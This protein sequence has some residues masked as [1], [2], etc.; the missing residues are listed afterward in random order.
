[1]LDYAAR[2]KVCE[3]TIVRSSAIAASTP[4]GS[5]TSTW[6][7]RQLGPLSPKHASYPNL[8]MAPIEV[9]N[10]DAFALARTLTPTTGKIGVLNLASNSEPG[11]GWCKTLSKTQE[12]ALCYSSTLYATLQPRFYPWPN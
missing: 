2:G 6:V 8:T 7:K 12:E 10:S 5:L 3:D 9:Y 4:G 1:M 11:G